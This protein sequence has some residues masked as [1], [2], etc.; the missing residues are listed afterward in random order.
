M[1]NPDHVTDYQSANRRYAEGCKDDRFEEWLEE[2]AKIKIVWKRSVAGMLT[3][4]DTN[5]PEVWHALGDAFQGGRGIE[6]DVEQAEKYYRMA[7]EAGHVRSMTR[8]GSLL[9]RDGRNPEDLTESIQ[10][11]RRAADLGDASG[12]TF[13]GF[14][15]REG[16]GVPVDE[17]EAA[18]WFIKA[19]S[20]GNVHAAELAGRLLS[21]HKENHSEAVKWLHIAAEHGDES[22]NYNLALI[23]EDRG[24]P[25]YNAEEAFRCWTCV[26][27]RPKG[28]DLRFMGM[29]TLARC[30]RNGIGT[31]RNRQQAIEWL[32]CLLAASPKKAYC[33]EATK[34]RKE[35]DEEI[36]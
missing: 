19:Y 35:I 5:E 8:L 23:H 24:S 13:L 11:F 28:N 32:D 6:K 10:W 33:R 3:Q 2:L 31:Q 21:Y 4:V 34:L 20:A 9:G 15:Y 26:A 1:S 12:M 36:P 17:R 14:G 29:L 27:E 25:E 16:R 7:S 22:A 18:D 30:C